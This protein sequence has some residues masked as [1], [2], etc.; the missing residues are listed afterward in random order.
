MTHEEY[1]EEVLALRPNLLVRLSCAAALITDPV[2]G[3]VIGLLDLT[4]SADDASPLMLCLARSGAREIE[5]SIWGGSA[6]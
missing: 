6:I 5:Q 3:A 4:S 2:T 1:V